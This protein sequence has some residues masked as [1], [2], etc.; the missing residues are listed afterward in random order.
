MRR[1]AIVAATGAVLTLITGAALVLIT[2]AGGVVAADG[3]GSAGG[4][5]D[6]GPGSRANP[7]A[8][9]GATTSVANERVAS[10][11][12]ER[13]APSHV[14]PLRAKPT[15][16]DGLQA[17]R[18]H[19]GQDLLTRCG[20]PV[21][22]ARGGRVRLR[23]YHGAAGNFVTIDGQGTSREYVY[24]HLAERGMPEEGERVETGERIGFV[25]TSGNAS[26]CH[27]HF[28]I[29][30]APGSYI[31]GTALDPAPALRRWE[32]RL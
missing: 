23:D 28:E 3:V 13:H 10:S 15:Y 30:T 18:G 26:T 2:G 21:L 22:A 8:T 1:A 4:A 5:P 16:G 32:A 17:G 12:P 9:R 14:F 19:R 27:L 6:V 20:R 31:G 25:S 24:Q 7:E 29:W 11:Q